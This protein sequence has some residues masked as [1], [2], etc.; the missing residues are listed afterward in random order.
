MHKSNG[1]IRKT[2]FSVFSAKI[3]LNLNRFWI[4][5]VLFF[6]ILFIWIHFFLLIHLHLTTRLVLF[7]LIWLIF[8]F[9]ALLTK[10]LFFFFHLS[11]TVFIILV[12]V[13]NSQLSLIDLFFSWTIF[14]ANCTNTFPYWKIPFHILICFYCKLFVLVLK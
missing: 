3:S 5:L 1:K 14:L 11:L 2:I 7:L 8:Q 13:R 6:K 9:Y 4:F 10:V 12:F